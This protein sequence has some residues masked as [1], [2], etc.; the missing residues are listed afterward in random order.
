M[1]QLIVSDE[2]ELKQLKVTD[3]SDIFSIIDSQREYLGKWL[4]FI[5]QTKT[6]DDTLAFIHSVNETPE[7]YRELAFC[8]FYRKVFAG[9]IGLK[10]NATDKANKRTEIGY[11]LSEK[12]QKKGIVSQSVKMLIDYAF[13]VLNLNRITIKCAVGNQSSI[14]LPKRLGFVFEGIE[15]DGEFFPDGHFVDLEIHSLLKKEWN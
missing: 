6:I 8:I 1:I 13:D 11:W 7:S 14:S 12:N 9:L 2:I 4:P 3:A 5:A 10:F 15:R